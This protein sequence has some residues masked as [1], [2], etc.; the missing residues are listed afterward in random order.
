MEGGVMGARR[1]AVNPHAADVFQGPEVEDLAVLTSAL[2][3][4]ALVGWPL[5]SLEHSG[6]GDPQ[7]T[8]MCPMSASDAGGQCWAWGPSHVN[9]A[10][11]VCLQGQVLLRELETPAL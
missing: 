7:A 11:E 10:V 4:M 2:R 1:G 5:P 6:Q 3:R 8:Q 9:W